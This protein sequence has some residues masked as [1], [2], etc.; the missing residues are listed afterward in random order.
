MTAGT[1]RRD[2]LRCVG[3]LIAAGCTLVEAPSILQASH[4]ANANEI[5]PIHTHFPD[6]D[7]I[8]NGFRPS[9]LVILAG[10]PC[11]GKTSLIIDIALKA[12]VN[13]GIPVGIF[14]LAQSKERV[15][16]DILSRV[17]GVSSKPK[18]QGMISP[19][20]IGLLL[21]HSK[22]LT[23]VPIWIDDTPAI[24]FRCFGEAARD[25]RK[26][27]SVKLIIVDYLQLMKDWKVS[28]G[29]VKRLKAAASDL[30]V[31]ILLI[32]SLSRRIDL[33]PDKRPKISDLASEWDGNQM[34]H[35]EPYVDIVLFTYRDRF[36][37]NP[38]LNQGQTTLIDRD[39]EGKGITEVII[40]KNSH[41][42]TGTAKLRFDKD[43]GR[44]MSQEEE[45][46][47]RTRIL[48]A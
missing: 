46:H 24:S 32:S 3:S 19:A 1:T 5:K 21:D 34:E 16:W 33:R 38:F 43:Y 36:L 15:A 40:A 37:T 6:L 13:D 29:V 47:G 20:Q 27:H 22:I 26:R 18:R 10:R 23:N 12:A 28:G 4:G 30:G 42:S 9:E 39:A 48:F 2:F 7:R 44:F 41:G 45:K 17:S 25:L 8:I 14:S 11:T 31:P 35:I